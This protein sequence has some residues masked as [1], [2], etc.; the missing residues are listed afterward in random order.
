MKTFMRRS[1]PLV[2]DWAGLV[3]LRPTVN[4]PGLPVLKV[5]KLQKGGKLVK[6]SKLL[7]KQIPV[8]E[9]DEPAEAVPVTEEPTPDVLSETEAAELAAIHPELIQDI[10]PQKKKPENLVR[11]RLV[12]TDS[13]YSL[14]LRVLKDGWFDAKKT[15]KAQILGLVDKIQEAGDRFNAPKEIV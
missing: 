5:G 13:E 7:N 3:A 11:L 6:L 14:L 10:I 4:W 8:E 9:D 2:V 12:L 1:V 15:Q